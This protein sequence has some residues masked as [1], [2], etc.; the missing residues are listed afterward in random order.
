MRCLGLAL[1]ILSLAAPASAQVA[2]PDTAASDAALAAELA[3]IHK[4]DQDG[5]MWWRR[6][7]ASYGGTAPDSLR[8]AF[9]SVQEEID[10]RTFAR[11]DSIVAARGWPGISVAGEQGAL[12]AF[13]VVQHAPLEAQERYLPVLEA[14]VAA[15]EAEPWHLAYLTDRV[16][17]RTDRPQRYGSQFQI[18]PETGERSYL[19]IEDE[20]RVNERRA[21]IGMPALDGFPPADS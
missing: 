2:A 16:L 17:V 3:E 12:T 19:P 10:A 4:L 18:D 1:L 6:V 7:Q 5:R 8:L 15:G 14:A 20:A 13:L 21:A 11:V 9:W